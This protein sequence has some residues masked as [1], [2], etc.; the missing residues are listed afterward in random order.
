MPELYII[1]GSN[2]AGKSTIGPDFLPNHIRQ[3]CTVFDGDLLFMRKRSALY[4]SG[5]RSHKECKKLAFAWLTEHFEEQVETA[6]TQNTD[7][8]YEGHF[9]N[10]ATWDIPRKFKEAGYEIHLIFFGLKD[11]TLSELRVVARTE[12][13][14][15][16]VDPITVADNFYGNLEKL[17][18]HFSLFD[19]V[20]IY[21]TSEIEYRL[22]VAVEAG[23]SVFAVSSEQLPTW[24]SVNMPV[25]TKHII[26]REGNT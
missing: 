4:I 12:E 26:N 2:G 13:G 22:L 8:C 5:I 19:S 1:T 9:T 18:Q 17:D 16:Y 23:I 15:H 6:I 25:I 10:E 14:G 7:F 24:F 20:Q 3:N 21:D 11:T